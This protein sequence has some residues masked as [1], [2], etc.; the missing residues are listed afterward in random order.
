MTHSLIWATLEYHS[1]DTGFLPGDPLCLPHVDYAITD[2]WISQTIY[3]MWKYNGL[4]HQ[5]CEGD[6]FLMEK[7]QDYFSGNTLATLNKVRL[8]LKVNTVSDLITADGNTYCIAMVKGYRN[9]D[10]NPSPSQ[11]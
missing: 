11:Q 1:L 6:V 3:S 7:F 10:N 2:T 5:W 8:Y 4:D 9:H